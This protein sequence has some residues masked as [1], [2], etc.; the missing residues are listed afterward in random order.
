MDTTFKLGLL[1]LLAGCLVVYAWRSSNGR[2]AYTENWVLDTR[3]GVI[4]R[5]QTCDFP[6]PGCVEL[7]A[8]Q[9]PKK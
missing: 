2:Y 6:A 9:N 7:T 5:A 8:G 3:T 4:Y 1:A